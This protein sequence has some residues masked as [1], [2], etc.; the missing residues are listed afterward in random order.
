MAV[1]R[2]RELAA[3]LNEGE[4]VNVLRDTSLQTHAE[5][6]GFGLY[7]VRNALPPSLQEKWAGRCSQMFLAKGR[8]HGPNS[9]K[10]KG[11]KNKRSF[12]H[13][14]PGGHGRVHVQ[15]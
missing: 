6:L 1:H 14:C 15:I 5:Q 7:V 11:A 8:E 9:V 4:Y 13:Q 3:A 12:L 2:G 10:A